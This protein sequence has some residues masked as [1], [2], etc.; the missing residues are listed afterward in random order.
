MK[1]FL[2]TYAKY[3]KNIAENEKKKKKKKLN[4]SKKQ[5]KKGKI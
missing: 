1:I 2:Y 4:S 3:R 5:K